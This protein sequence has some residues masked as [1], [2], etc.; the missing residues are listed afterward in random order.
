MKELGQCHST[1][2]GSQELES[3]AGLTKQLIDKTQLRNLGSKEIP[4]GDFTPPQ[5]VR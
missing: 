4:V 1:A 5:T 3:L 2:Q